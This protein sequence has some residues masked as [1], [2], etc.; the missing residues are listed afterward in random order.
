MAQAARTNTPPTRELEAHYA[1][2]ESARYKLHLVSRTLEGL[3]DLACAGEMDRARDE[4]AI[5]QEDLS[6]IFEM[7][8][9]QITA[10]VDNLTF[11]PAMT[12][13]AKPDVVFFERIS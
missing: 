5:K 2:S 13:P 1:L 8:R 11:V 12:I 7:V 3:G 9:M 10:V 6:A 4:V